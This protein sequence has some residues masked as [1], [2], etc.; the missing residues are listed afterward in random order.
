MLLTPEPSPSPKQRLLTH[1][2][3][4]PLGTQGTSHGA[5][6][7]KDEKERCAMLSSLM[8][9]L[10]TKLTNCTRPAQFKLMTSVNIAAGSTIQTQEMTQ[11]NKNKT[12]K[13]GRGLLRGVWESKG[14]LLE[15]FMVKIHCVHV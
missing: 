12:K 1:Q 2:L 5:E 10:C 15:I 8:T 14:E 11:K 13:D 4:T 9:W 7:G 6:G 3:F